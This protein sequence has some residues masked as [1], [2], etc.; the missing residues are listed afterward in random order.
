[1]PR[2]HDVDLA[3]FAGDAFKSR[4]PTPTF[5]REFA[6]RVQDLA[7]LCPVVLLVGNHDLPS[8]ERR[9]SSVEIYETL[10][11]PE[12]AR[13]A[14]LHSARDRDQ[15]RPGGG[16]HRALP[17]AP[18]PA[19]EDRLAAQ[20]DDCRDRRDAGRAARSRGC[21]LAEEAS[22][23]D[24]PR[25]L[26]GHFSV[27][28]A[29]FGSERSVM[30]GR[31]VTVHAQHGRSPGVGLRGD[32]A[33]PQAPIPDAWAAPDRR[34]SSTAA[35]WSGSTL[36]KKPIQRASS[37]SNWSGAARL[38]ICPGQLPPV[39]DAARGRAPRRRIRPQVVLEEIPATTCARPS[40]A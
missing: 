16:R 34:R 19:A 3:I 13:R 33:H 5:Q 20:Q 11:R 10:Q 36:A 40:C 22:Q 7:T 4:N 23:Y 8:I 21:T 31:D 35:A 6:Y 30:L 26:T 24:M 39:R 25:I 29:M 2:D 28:G 1:M 32:G 14:R 37:G 12:Y 15:A 38:G 9:A 27:T 18:P 17:D